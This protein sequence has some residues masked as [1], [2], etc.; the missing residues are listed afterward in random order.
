MDLDFCEEAVKLL[1]PLTS[2]SQEVYFYT[3][4]IIKKGPEGD[5]RVLRKIHF[6]GLSLLL[7][8]FRI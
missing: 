8:V 7:S 4:K 2:Q 6:I 1:A 5:K 3:S